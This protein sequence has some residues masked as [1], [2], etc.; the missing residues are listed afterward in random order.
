[1][2]C[3][4]AVGSATVATLGGFSGL[5]A[6][7]LLWVQ[8]TEQSVVIEGGKV[9][10]AN[11]LKVSV[12]SVAVG[13]LDRSD[14]VYDVG[15]TRIGVVLEGIGTTIDVGIKPGQVGSLVYISEEDVA[16]SLGRNET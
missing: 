13:T 12:H 1:M 10:V 15:L 16:D 4:I 9:L 6:I 5:D 8:L 3:T 7:T 14:L 11:E 2:H